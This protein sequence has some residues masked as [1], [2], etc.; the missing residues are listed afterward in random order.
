MK[1]RLQRLEI[2]NFKGCRKAD[3]SFG[4]KTVISGRNATG[5]TTIADAFFWLLFNQDSH[6][7]A[8]GSDKFREKPV[9]ENGSEIHH[10]DT[11]VT[12]HCT[13]DGNPFVLKRLQRESW[14]TKRGSKDASYGGNSSTYWIND[15]ETKVSDYNERINGIAN[16]DL[17]SVIMK[18]GAFNQLDKNRKRTML[19]AMSG[20][21][22]DARLIDHP[23]YKPLYDEAAARGI[24]MDDLKKVY[25]DQRKRINQ[26][27]TLLPAKMEEVSYMIPAYTDQEIKDAEFYAEDTER[28]MEQIRGQIAEAESGNGNAGGEYELLRNEQELISQKRKVM[29]EF[30]ARKR[31]AE[32]AN[33]S[34]M[35]RLEQAKKTQ[36][37]AVNMMANAKV[38]E[39]DA[40]KL[41]NDTRAE[42]RTVY[43]RAFTPPKREAVCPTCGQPITDACWEET[44]KAQKEAFEARKKAD[45]DAVSHRGKEYKEKYEAALKLSEAAE[46]E[47][48]SADQ[49]VNDANLLFAQTSDTLSS[50]PA[51]PDFNI[52]AIRDL[53]AKIANLKAKSNVAPDEKIKGLRERLSE[54][55]ERNSRARATLAKRDRKAECE[56]RLA[57]LKEEQ[58]RLGQ[59]KADAEHSIY[60]IE[61]L[62]TERC[63]LL[64]E[65]INDLFPTVRWKLFDRQINGAIA[66]CCECMVPGPESLMPYSGTNT[67]A[68][69]NA[70][71][72]IIGVLS[73]YYDL[74][75]PVFVDNAEC[76]NYIAQPEGQLIT[77]NVSM[78]DTLK[79]ETKEAA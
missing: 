22:V 68:R 66:D 6:G 52:P 64:E 7:N 41:L 62:I 57:Q 44:L 8:P 45:K 76:V 5:K 59:K 65:Q 34:A 13:L 49:E 40:E 20:A 3:Y 10:L 42:Y 29:D 38:H 36:D 70:D 27:L 28:D 21:N 46:K 77:L 35:A 30:E 16:G 25:S 17:L 60:L 54:L 23:D 1:M 72:E 51:V 9:D 14:V 26:E 31:S 2:E 48:A 53:E 15:V 58:P 55:T 4:D 61:R 33:R 11:V 32:E 79:V 18:L 71:I 37:V 74:V 63:G 43:A 73:K 56:A 12:A 78:D 69:I 19:L 47:L 24:T 67:A 39:G 75:V 50:L